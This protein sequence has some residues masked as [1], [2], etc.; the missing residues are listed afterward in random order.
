MA[1][2]NFRVKNGL[3]VGIGGTIITA[4]SGGLVG[5][6]TTNPGNL[7]DVLSTT[8]GATV[9][10]KSTSSSAGLSLDAP[11]SLSA[12][13][14]IVY[15]VNGVNKWALGGANIGAASSTS[16]SLYNYTAGN[17]PFTI[18]SDSN[19]LIVTASSTGTSSQ[20]LQVNSGAYVSG[21][22][23]VGVT[24][25]A[26]NTQISVAGTFGISESGGT[27]NRTF[28][29]T[30]AAGF[31]LNHN[32]NSPITFQ[33]LG[34]EKFRWDYTAAALL[35]GNTAASG[36]ASQPLQVTGG[37]YVSGN[38]GVGVAN[39]SYNLDINGPIRYTN[40]Q[41]N[42]TFTCERTFDTSSISAFANG[43][44][45]QAFDVRIGNISVWGYIEIEIT[46]TFAYQ[47]TAGILRKIFSVGTNPTNLIYLNQ[48]RVSE[49]MGAIVDNISIGEF[50]WDAT[51]S[52]YKIPISHILSSGNTYVV[53]VKAF[54]YG[55]SRTLYDNLSLGSVYTLTALSPNDV[56]Y[57]TRNVL[58][59]TQ[60]ATGT[61]S[62]PLQVTGGAYVSG[63]V[64]IGSA[65]PSGKF[66]I[67][68][69][70]Q[71]Y[72][73]SPAIT[74]TDT[75]GNASANRWIIGNIATQ[76]G[77]FNIASAPSPSS[78]TYTP[79]LTIDNNGNVLIN[80]SS[81]PTG[82]SSQ[83][84]QV[85]GGASFVGTGSSIGIGITNPSSSLH[86]AKSTG[87]VLRVTTLTGGGGGNSSILMGNQD[88][89]GTNAPAVIRSA[90]TVIQFGVGNSWSDEY[91]GTFTERMRIDGN[92]GINTTSTRQRLTIGSLTATSTA[93]PESIDL[94]G[95]YS[96]S[97][98]TNLKLKLYNDGTLVHGLGVSNASTDYVTVSSG[99]HT[100]YRGS[101]Q[102]VQINSSGNLGINTTTPLQKLHV[103][104][105]LL[106]AAGS[107]TGQ[108][109]T[110]KAYELNSGTL[111]WEGSAGQLFS[112]T[113]NLTSGSIFS[114]NDVSGIPSIDVNANGTISMAPYGGNIGFGIT[115]PT[116]RIGIGGTTG[117]SF[118]DTNIRLGDATTGRSITSGIYN[119]FMGVGAGKSTTTG[120]ANNFFGYGAGCSNISGISNNFFGAYAGKSNTIGNTN[121]F[122]GPYAG[123][124]NTTGSNNNFF[125]F[126][127]GKCNTT[128]SYN[129]I[130][131]CG[132]GGSFGANITG[133]NNNFFGA[134]TGS[135][136]TSGSS[137]NFFGSQAGKCN[138][139]GSYNNFLG[140]FAGCRNSTGNNNNFFGYQAGIYN[141]SGGYN[142]F[143]GRYAGA[144]SNTACYNN[145]LGSNAGRNN[146]SGS[147]NNFL[148]LGAGNNNSTGNNNNF[149]GLFAGYTNTTGSDNI[150]IGR[151]ALY[152][153]TAPG[154]NNIAIGSSA[155][156]SAT[157]GLVSLG[158]SNNTIVMGNFNHTNAYIKIA[159]TVTSD[160]RDKGN[161]TP[162]PL[163]LSFV[164]KLV[165]IE[166]N[167]IDRNTKENTDGTRR[168]GFSAQN[169][170]ENETNPSILVDTRDPD[171]LKL[172]ESMMIPVLV[173]AIKEL[174]EE[175]QSL[176]QEVIIIKDLLTRAGIGSL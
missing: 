132:A 146:N 121:N 23:G 171:H 102:V 38:L 69:S 21:K 160:E 70:A 10:I 15:L 107:S 150:A 155:G 118:S 115:N 163:G 176:K 94:G 110:Q 103:L 90:N 3:E 168:Y 161:I 44:A 152:P 101:T 25:P 123:A 17:N 159:W 173:N 93:T 48:S 164:Q 127:A 140:S 51:N 147:C 67:A 134:L 91:G 11:T 54:T 156:S 82:T 120:N 29:S 36:T 89:A 55:Q 35:I 153:A 9:R 131:G 145:F 125:G 126:Y 1:N 88:S 162:V 77:Y 71:N 148:G 111:S 12:S 26:T 43:V 4:S 47:N 50:Q 138:T 79:R 20:A 73:T 109:I 65:V 137:N 87:A 114:V 169:I 117:I 39:P 106:V 105:N 141:G 19:F 158:S 42:S 84:L 53:K 86:I 66:D 64:G 116:T 63:P 6:G 100:F 74:F 75:S 142:N 18:D 83:P 8:S 60:T 119:N 112:I 7:I 104:G 157:P 167:W 27:G 41:I 96:N 154:S 85:T 31:V 149:F 22:L 24:N 45:N 57:P 5:I 56:T 81:S 58:I 33:V 172:R 30:S 61:A 174:S 128:G 92:V 52:T 151:S 14:Q 62:Q 37:A 144:Y 136:N 40:G 59:G 95:T 16:F 72:S 139:T 130:F 80:N 68:S 108:H 28:F 76:Y 2:Q 175:N 34:S 13:P 135:I 143:F 129:N 97:A 170:L 49:A 166:Y 113:N 98:G 99:S 122:F 32:D 133:S 124:F 46:G 165:P 78:T